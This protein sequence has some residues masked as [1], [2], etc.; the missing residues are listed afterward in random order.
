MSATLTPEEKLKKKSIAQAKSA[1]ENF[2]IE[3]NITKILYVDDKCSIND[4]KEIFIGNLSALK[5][6]NPVLELF[7]S[8]SGSATAFKSRMTKLWDDADESEK[9]ELYVK[10]LEFEGN[11]EDIENSMAPLKLKEHLGDKIDLFSPTEWV[12]QKDDVLAKLNSES[13]VLCLFDI[14]FGNAPPPDGR[15]GI[16]L[17]VEVLSI[18]AISNY[19]FCGIFSHLF[20]IN[21]EFERRNEISNSES[22]DKEKFYTISKKRFTSSDYLPA[23]A[24][25]IRNTLLIS[26]IE[27]LKKESTSIIKSS[28][29]KSLKELK[30]LTPSTFNHVIQKSSRKEG[31]WEMTNLLRINSIINTDKSLNN[32]ISKT[33]REKIN[34]SLT[35]IR[36]VEKIKTGGDTPYDKN[37]LVSLRKREILIDGRIINELHFPISN[38]DIFRIEDKNY[39]LLGQPC[40]LA[41]RTSGKRD[42][43]GGQIFS[44]AFLLELE[45]VENTLLSKV[46]KSQLL[47]M[48]F[49]EKTD[50]TNDKSEIVRFPLFKTISL[51]PLDLTVFNSDGR[52]KINF[53]QQTSSLATIQDSWKVRYQQLHK[54]F[55]NYKDNIRIFKKLKSSEKQ[56]IKESIYYGE[57]FKGFK[58]NNDNCLNS[59]SS[60]LTLNIKRIGHYKSPYSADLLQQFMDYLSRNAFER[61]F[62]ND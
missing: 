49:I 58:L 29:N 11:L 24:E 47:T 54:Q 21:Q 30:E 3:L 38:G 4:L 32:L 50:L 60:I 26:E 44:T 8:W 18:D 34:K 46:S 13:R 10:L 28:F 36:R 62:L 25:G 7:G 45:I 40:N 14:D 48:G 23:L 43:R 2:L 39:I 42:I 15:N 16:A 27:Y 59:T 31:N 20:N 55:S 22:I 33:K 19:V 6:T 17:A 57:L 12:N 37:Q 5:R 35:N 51:A 61:N 53:N 1:I 41:L 56:S 52:A 9:R